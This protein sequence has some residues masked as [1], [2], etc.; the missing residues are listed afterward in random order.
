MKDLKVLVVDDDTESCELIKQY[1]E[2]FC[3]DK[4]LTIEVHY[5]IDFEQAL[6]YL[7]DRR[8][9]L[10]IL[11]VRVGDIQEDV[12]EEDEAGRKTLQTI[13]DSLFVPVI[14]HTGLP[15]AVADLASNL[16]RV[17]PRETDSLQKILEEISSLVE[18]G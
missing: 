3:D 12:D 13:Q 11:D 6:R 1:L 2:E 14:F 18:T 15:N 7:S 10:L 4:N 17:V 9:D 8:I 5:I 16:I